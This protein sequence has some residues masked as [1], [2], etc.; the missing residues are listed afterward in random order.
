M[1]KSNNQEEIIIYTDG[2]C[3]GN[4]G[5]GGFGWVILFNN[6]L[7]EHSESEV[8]TTNNRMEISAI[9][10][11]LEFF[12][13]NK[14]SDKN[15]KIIIHTDSELISNSINKNW[16]SSWSRNG[17][18][19]ADKQ[20]VKNQDLWERLWELISKYLVDFVWVKAHNG[21]E[22][23][24]K[25]DKLATSA[26]KE[27]TPVYHKIFVLK[28]GIIQS[29]KSENKTIKKKEKLPE[30]V[31]Y[32]MKFTLS[33]K[34]D[35]LYIQQINKNSDKSSSSN[36]SIIVNSKNVDE[37]IEKLNQFKSKIKI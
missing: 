6:K 29:E 9:V 30:E 4:P 27:Q 37:L 18:R 3:S 16:L 34:K 26:S 8:D 19:K 22:Y 12:D 28:D 7:I 32:V 1:T 15:Y 35:T 5:P 33:T 25:C 31:D 23:N 2:A 10:S 17:W 24:E 21:N 11:V 14:K 36:P 20:P 13:K